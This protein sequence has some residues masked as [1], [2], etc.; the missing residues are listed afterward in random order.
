[1]AAPS[2]IRPQPETDNGVRE[3]RSNW[4]AVTPRV[5]FTGQYPLSATCKCA[6]QIKSVESGIDPGTIETLDHHTAYAASKGIL[7]V[8]KGLNKCLYNV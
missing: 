4:L 8:I 7:S 2:Y 3:G 5:L 1:M 6:L